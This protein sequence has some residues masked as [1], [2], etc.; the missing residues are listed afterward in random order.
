MNR[1]SLIRFFLALS[2]QMALIIAIPSVAIYTHLTG[3][4]VILQTVPVDPYDFLRGYSQTLRYQ[5]SRLDHIKR[6]SG[7]ETVLR[8]TRRLDES[9][10]PRGTTVYVILQ[11]PA[12]PRPSPRPSPWSAIAVRHEPPVNLG[13]NQVAIK[14]QLNG[15]WIDYG[16]E[17]YYFPEQQRQKINEEIRM[18]QQNNDQERPFVVEVKV[19]EGGNAVP[20]SLWLGSKNYRF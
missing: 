7:W 9:L 19:D 13:D 6:L 15:S 14:G 16:L 4:K 10:P 18:L 1:R 20:V 17:R 2:F 12:S 5:I 11:A 3:E 8:Q